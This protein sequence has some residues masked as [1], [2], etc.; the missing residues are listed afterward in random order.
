MYQLG[1]PVTVDAAQLWKLNHRMLTVV[2]DACTARF[3]ELGIDPKEYF[4]LAEVADS[5]YPAELATVLATPK[6]SVTNYVRSLVSKG[7]MRREIDAVDLRKHRLE[8]TAEGV[9]T[10]D[11]ASAALAEEFERRLGV[12]TTE[13]REQLQTILETI[14]RG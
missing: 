4:V 2:L 7:L 1:G 5:P 8:L 11:A 6:A 10:R 9:T 3:T 12:V 13:Q 14:L